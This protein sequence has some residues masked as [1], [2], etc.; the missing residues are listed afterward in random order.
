MEVV[1][2][3]LQYEFITIMFGHPSALYRMLI[4]FDL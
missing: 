3:L 2:T 4:S 1:S